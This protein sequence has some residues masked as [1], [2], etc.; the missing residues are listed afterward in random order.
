MKSEQALGNA[1]GRRN[2]GM[3][4]IE[5]IVL[6]GIAWMQAHMDEWVGAAHDGPIAEEICASMHSSLNGCT[7]ADMHAWLR[8]QVDH[9]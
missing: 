5:M 4:A 7:V 8:R 9:Q 3:A 2:D 6:E 1:V